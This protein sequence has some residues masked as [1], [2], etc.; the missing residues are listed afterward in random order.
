MR[1]AVVTDFGEPDVIEVREVP[2]TEPGPGQAVIRVAFADVLW[3]E[4]M[5]RRGLG[6]DH[7]DHEP[8]Y[9]PG[10]GVAGEVSA[11][12]DGVGK[13]WLA[14]QAVAHT[15]ERGGYAERAVVSAEALVAVPTGVDLREAAALLH[16]GVT[17]LRLQEVTGYQAGSR[18]L[19]VGASGGLGIASIQLARARGAHVVATARDERKLARIRE[20]GPDGLIDS[21][22][23]NWVASARAALGGEGADVVLDN[24]GGAV[25]GAALEA[26]APG[27]RF[28][29]HGTPSGSF[30]E[31]D[32]DTAEARNVTIT[33]IRAV[34]VSDA[35][36]TRLTR[37]ALDELA[38][39]HLRPVIG[40]TFSLT[41]AADA[42]A[43]IETRAVFGKT[44]LTVAGD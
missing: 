44:L 23:R 4:A 10:N 2:D 36:L 43:A 6:R 13:Q 34:Q 39:G 40:Q 16:D 17:A 21:E 22:S 38:A 32:R 26:I 30:A 24:V 27:G 7:F 9:I 5:I 18:V 35:D 42:H 41:R 19:V 3:V 11:V 37:A 14:R 25:G 20:V 29:A 28:S 1:A 8:P 33:D 15:G 31:I 12:G